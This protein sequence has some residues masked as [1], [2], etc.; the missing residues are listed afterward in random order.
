M[1]TSSSR[2]NQGSLP[3]G[4]VIGAASKVVQDLFTGMSGGTPG[5]SDSLPQYMQ[6]FAGSVSSRREGQARGRGGLPCPLA[7]TEQTHQLSDQKGLESGDI[8]ALG[9]PRLPHL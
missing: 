1:E 8:C 9:G 7:F 6:G 3:G 4:G 5:V 2:W